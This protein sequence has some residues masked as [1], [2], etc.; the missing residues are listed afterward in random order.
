MDS[1]LIFI[2]SLQVGLNHPTRITTYRIC[3]LYLLK[4]YEFVMV[5]GFH[6]PLCI[7]HAGL[8]PPK[9]TLQ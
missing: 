2:L 1:L 7:S 5:D 9:A 6:I 8:E 3:A 4:I